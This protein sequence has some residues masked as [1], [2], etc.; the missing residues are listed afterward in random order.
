MTETA[1]KAFKS[2]RILWEGVFQKGVLFVE[3]GRITG[4]SPDLAASQGAVEDFG[5]LAILPG[6]V[7]THVHV[8]EPGRTEWEGFE[9]ATHAAAAGGVTTLID[10]PLNCIPVTTSK[11]ALETKIQAVKDLLRVDVGFWGGVTRDSLRDLPALLAHES[12]FGVKSFLIDSGIEEFPPVSAGDLD[13]AMPLLARAGLPYLFHAELE[14]PAD[15]EAGKTY[16]S[17]LRSRPD[18]WETRAVRLIAEKT[19]LYRCKSHIVHLSSAESLAIVGKAKA[20]GVSLTAETCPHYL[21]LT[22]E[23]IEE[24]APAGGR[25]VFKCCPPIRDQGNRE[26]LWQ[27]LKHGILDFVVSDHSPCTPALKLLDSSDFAKGWGGIASLQLTLP[28]VWT[29]AKK[30]GFTLPEV[31]R[32]LSEKPA[33]F[34]GLQGRKGTLS[35]GSDADFTVFDP[36]AK[37]VVR[38]KGIHHRHKIT[39]YDGWELEGRVE[40]TYLRGRKIYGEGQLAGGA[41]GNV[42]KRKAKQ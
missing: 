32:L 34:A 16:G 8:N 11:E 38:A 41:H 30:R 24:E 12:L 9:T 37:F 39:P 31:S 1:K 18:D 6:L 19:A 35:P 13:V 22:S 23:W 33:L 26:R 10:M 17:F 29:E 5:S 7:D 36:D 20:E 4:Y 2:E 3:A 40:S 14:G 25:T 27:A 15:E 42:L 21:C 28:L